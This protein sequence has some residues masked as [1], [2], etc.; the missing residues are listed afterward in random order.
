MPAISDRLLNWGDLEEDFFDGGLLVGNG[1]SRAVFADFGYTSLYDTAR[2]R[3]IEHPLTASDKKLFASLET[4]NF[5]EVLRAL[6]TALLQLALVQAV[7]KVHLE[8]SWI[9]DEVL[10]SIRQE[11]LNYDFVYSTNYDLLIYWAM[12][13]NNF[14]GFVDYFWNP[15]RSFDITNT[16]VFGKVTKVL[17]LHGG[18]HLIRFPDGTTVKRR[19]S[20]FNLLEKFSTDYP[21]GAIPLFISEGSSRDKLTSIYQSDYLSFAYATFADHAGPLVVFGHNLSQQDRHL[22][23]RMKEWGDRDIAIGIRRTTRTSSNTI[24]SR[25][26]RYKKLLPKARLVFFDASTHPIGSGD[27]RCGRIGQRLGE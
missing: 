13:A 6:T 22:V 8:W 19:K 5:E 7:A 14:S 17:W 4:R 1:A 9:R 24:I 26:A 27:L 15:D 18:L 12:G 16:E 2:S 25:K 20:M 21:T 23:E 10:L 11:L 3:D